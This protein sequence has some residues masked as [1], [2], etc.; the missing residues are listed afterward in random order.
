M[1][2]TV[3]WEVENT[4]LRVDF[5]G[6]WTD[7]EY[8][9]AVEAANDLVRTAGVPVAVLLNMGGDVDTGRGNAFASGKATLDKMPQNVTRIGIV[10]G[11]M[12]GRSILTTFFNVYQRVSRQRGIEVRMY[13]SV[14]VARA[15]L[16]SAN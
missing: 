15:A 4:L 1:G 3:A 16:L 12:F 10:A 5:A 11:N 7:A 2:I 9:A 13:D 8:T 14:E 6:E